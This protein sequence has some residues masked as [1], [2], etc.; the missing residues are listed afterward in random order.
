MKKY[1]TILVILSLLVLAGC[2]EKTKED[3]ITKLEDTLESMSGYQ[4]KAT[5]QL[6]TSEKEQSYALDIAHKKK[7]YYRVLLKNDQDEA[8]SQ[9]I[10]KNEDGVFVLTPALNKS[11][12]FQSDW[13]SNTSQPYLFQSLVSDIKADNDATFNITENYYVFETKTNYQNNTTLPSQQ[14]YFDKKQFTPVM[15]KVLNKDQEAVVEVSFSEFKLDPTFEDK[16]FEMENNMTSSLFGIPASAD[17]EN[18]SDGELS[19]LYPQNLLGSELA[20]T[21]E[22]DLEDGQRVLL[23]YEGEKNFTLVQ[24]KHTS[25]PTTAMKPQTVTGNPVSLGFTV[26]AQTDA[27]LEWSHQGVDYYLASEE[28]TKEEMIEVA[29]SITTQVS[30]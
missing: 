24:E 7:A 19:V 8:G 1:I 27:A 30:K 11:F 12:K 17:V 15:V 20:E 2:G 26:G 5:M 28:L 25:Y 4:T 21:T 6:K 29:T 3:V 22:I 9:I 16:M 18:E 14:I 13:P 10:L 23:S